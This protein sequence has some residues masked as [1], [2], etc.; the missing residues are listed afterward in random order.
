MR[1]EE[2]LKCGHAGVPVEFPYLS[3]TK[4]H[5]A[6]KKTQ[7]NWSYPAVVNHCVALCPQADWKATITRQ[8][9]VT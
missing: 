4:M 3:R 1:V 2:G 7:Q 9:Y 5:Q 8:D 6:S